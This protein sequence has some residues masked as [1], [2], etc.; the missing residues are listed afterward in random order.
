MLTCLI[1]KN[2]QA[3]KLL[4]TKSHN[5]THVPPNL[6]HIGQDGCLEAASVCVSNEEH[7]KVK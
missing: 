1:W 2:K 7:W 3:R 5:R 4:C 6:K